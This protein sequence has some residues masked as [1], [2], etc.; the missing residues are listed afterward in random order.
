MESDDWSSVIDEQTQ[1]TLPVNET[2]ATA[3]VP[4]AAV[5]AR[6]PAS[7]SWPGPP[8]RVTPFAQARVHRTIGQPLFGLGLCC[9]S[10]YCS[11]L[12][13]GSTGTTP[14]DFLP[15]LDNDASLSTAPGL[16]HV[17]LQC[18]SLTAAGVCKA[19]GDFALVRYCLQADIRISFA[20]QTP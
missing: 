1:G 13:L 2:A 10:R 11:H 16:A 5:E 4:A 3:P 14:A 6:Q 15:D 12:Q 9:M 18:C 20:Q 8:A 17:R 7:S 19:D